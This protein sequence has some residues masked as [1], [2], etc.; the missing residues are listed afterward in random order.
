M[1]N[2]H[3]CDEILRMVTRNLKCPVPLVD[4]LRRRDEA[5][6]LARAPMATTVLSLGGLLQLEEDSFLELREV[7]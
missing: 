6:R 1:H 7:I 5:C 2:S 4:L 3:P